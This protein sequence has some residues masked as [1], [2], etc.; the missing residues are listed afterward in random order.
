M[1]QGKKVANILQKKRK[2]GVP[3]KKLRYDE[4]FNINLNR[5][6]RNEFDKYSSKRKIK[7]FTNDV[8]V[9]LF[10]APTTFAMGLCMPQDELAS[11]CLYIISGCA[12]VY[13]AATL[14]SHNKEKQ[15]RFTLR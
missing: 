8:K 1:T 2:K 5:M 9:A 13:A 3:K 6:K 4:S 12:I 14:Y 10:T 11:N 15:K 7:L